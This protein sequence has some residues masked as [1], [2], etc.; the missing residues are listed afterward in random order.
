MIKVL[1][2]VPNLSRKSGVSSFLMNLYRN[3]DRDEIQ[4]DFLV[5]RRTEF[6]YQ[7]EIESL[8]GSV[9]YSPNPLSPSLFRAVR[10]FR[11]FFL[12]NSDN[13]S[14][15]HIHSPNLI[16][17]VAPLARQ[18]KVK[19]IIAHSHSSKFSENKIKHLINK[20]LAILGRQ[21]VTDKW[22]CSPE[23]GKFL[24]GENSSYVLVNNAIDPSP[25]RF[26]VEIRDSVRKELQIENKKVICHVSNFNRLKNTLFL[27]D[28]IKQ[29][30]QSSEDYIFLFV[31]DGE[32][33]AKLIKKLS[34]QNLLNKCVFVGFQKNIARYLNASDALLLPS[35][36]EGAPVILIEAQSNGLNCIVS[37]S[38]TR[39]IDVGLCCFL[40]LIAST[41]AKKILSLDAESQIRR[42]N[43]FWKISD[44]SYNIKNQIAYVSNLYK[45]KSDL[46]KNEC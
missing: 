29:I 1:Q 4:F 9:F 35:K 27:I 40:P 39:N 22:S 18:A 45:Q 3:I 20:L 42:S 7:D 13:Y 44:S 31:G 24:F 43:F 34:T 41:W 11:K 30:N 8:G 25:F 10:Y 38:V 17:F 36:H 32:D 6:S 5:T 12:N 16:A 26:N 46:S 21:Y 37:D 14:V 15:V 28:V 23:A 33:K 2:V 19:T